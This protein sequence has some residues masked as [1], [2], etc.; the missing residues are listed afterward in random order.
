[1]LT[2]SQMGKKGGSAGRGASKIRGDS[3]YYK[4]IRAKRKP[5]AAC[6]NHSSQQS[7]ATKAVEE[8]FTPQAEICAKCAEAELLARCVGDGLSYCPWCGRKLSPC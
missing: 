4:N 2:A 7:F 3:D 1:M 6:Q 8:K 5:K